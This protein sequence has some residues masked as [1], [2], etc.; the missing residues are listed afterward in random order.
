MI[1]AN[2]TGEAP[3]LTL[4]PKGSKTAVVT[5]WDDGSP[6]DLRCAEI[7]HKYG[8]HPS[9]FLNQGTAMMKSLD[10]LEALGIEIGAHGYHHVSLHAIPPSQAAEEC[11]EIRRVL[12][13]AL[14]HPVISYA[15]PN[16]YTPAY[17]AQGDYVLRAVK[18]AG[19]W[20]GR[21][22]HTKA[23]TVDSYKDL[24]AMDTDG[25]FGNTRPLEAAW[26]A[27]RAKNGGIFYFWGHSWQI[28]KTDE[29]WKQFDDFVA[30]FAN[31]PDTW[32]ASQGDLSLWIWA[33]MNLQLT[34]ESKGPGQVVVKLNRP[35]LH[36]YLSAKLPL[37]L[38]VPAGVQKVIWQGQEVPVTNGRVDVIWNN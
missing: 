3:A 8:Y 15:Y 13:K 6:D 30:Q 17:D 5:T 22:T 2:L 25:F 33:R 35:W 20:S 19:Y 7:L 10:K 16:G 34:V 1:G 11:A 18:A 21:T 14:K 28:G 32:Y 37:S 12:E 36:P 38:A 4:L 9:F 27:A 24:V 26:A 29:Q 31:Q 23:E